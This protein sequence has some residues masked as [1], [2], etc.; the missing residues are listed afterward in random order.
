METQ[1]NG[2][3]SA[4]RI[5]PVER[6]KRHGSQKKDGPNIGQ[7]GQLRNHWT[8]TRKKERRG[9]DMTQK[10]KLKQ[11]PETTGTEIGTM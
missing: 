1:N 8:K 3:R 4:K 2:G 11:Q 5:G 7:H 6:C 9:K 10:R